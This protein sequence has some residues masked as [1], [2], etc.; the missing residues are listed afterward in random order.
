MRWYG[1]DALAVV[2][3]TGVYLLDFVYSSIHFYV[4][5]SP[6]LCFISFLYTIDIKLSIFLLITPLRFKK[7][8]ERK[9]LRD[10]GRQQKQNTSDL[11]KKSHGH[12]NLFIGCKHLT[13]ITN[14]F[15]KIQRKQHG[16]H[17]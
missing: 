15:Y 13:K 4:L 17:E 2:R 14:K 9:L 3:P 8:Q 1:P 11:I 16:G 6:S 10:C 12:S 7:W 5:L